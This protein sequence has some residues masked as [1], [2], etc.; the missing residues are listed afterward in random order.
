[1]ESIRPSI[2]VHDLGRR[3]REGLEFQKGPSVHRIGWAY[4]WIVE[5]MPIE[6]LGPCICEG[7]FSR[8]DGGAHEV[9]VG[10]GLMVSRGPEDGVAG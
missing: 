2:R 6:S 1:M 3:E 5:A 8:W 10:D 7:A 4:G 9:S